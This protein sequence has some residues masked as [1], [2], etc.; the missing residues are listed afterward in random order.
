MSVLQELDEL[1]GLDGDEYEQEIRRLKQ[2]L[3]QQPHTHWQEFMA[4][5]GR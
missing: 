5:W 1:L 4:A 3:Q 2:Y